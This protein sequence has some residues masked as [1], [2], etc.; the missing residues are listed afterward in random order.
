MHEEGSAMTKPYTSIMMSATP[1][2][3][4]T[5]YELP[6]SVLGPAVAVDLRDTG[7]SLTVRFDEI[8]PLDA[9]INALCEA[10]VRLADLRAQRAG[11]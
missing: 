9:L 2:T 1:G 8:A 11:A 6:D 3:Q 7:I 4:P 10:R 5:I